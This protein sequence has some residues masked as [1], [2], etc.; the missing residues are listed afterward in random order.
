MT[1][2][3][4]LHP[5]RS[6]EDDEMAQLRTQVRRRVRK[7]RSVKEMAVLVDDMIDALDATLVAA[8]PPTDALPATG[9]IHGQEWI[10]SRWSCHDNGHLTVE[11]AHQVA[12][13]HMDCVPD[14]AICR[15]KHTAMSVLAAAAVLRPDPSRVL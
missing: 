10:A 9:P 3:T 2:D 1:L 13:E 6:R 4:L 15:V 5:F 8:A 12:R 11:E 14:R 7:V